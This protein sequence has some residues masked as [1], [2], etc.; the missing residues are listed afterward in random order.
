MDQKIQEF[1]QAKRLAVVGVSHTSTKFG[2]AI[3]TELKARGFDVFGVNP[4]LDQIG[5]DKCYPNLAALAGKV[6]G[7][8]IC[9]TP[10]KGCPGDSRSICCRDQE[11][12]AATGI[13]IR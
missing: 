6:D 1:V 4:S 9:V 3:Y 10:Q 11:C 5:G 7:V 13:A 12:L 2:N 8:V